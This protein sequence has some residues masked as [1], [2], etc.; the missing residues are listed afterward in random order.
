MH[1]ARP[2]LRDLFE[3][4]VEALPLERARLL[5]EVQ[6]QSPILY[7]HL[8]D[9]LR[10]HEGP[11]AIFDLDGGVWAQL[12]PPSLI[13]RRF[14]AYVIESE[15][16]QGGMGTVYRATRADE[17][18]HKTVAIKIVSGAAVLNESALESF[19]RE[20][21]ILAHLEHPG[22]ARLLD[23]GATEDGL[24]FLVMEFV[25][26]LPF[27]RYLKEKS[28]G[29][30]EILRIVLQVASAVS[31]AH[32][33]LVVHRDLKPSNILVDNAGQVKLLDFGIAKVLKPDASDTRTM[34]VRLTP[35]FASPEQIRGESIS[36]SSDVY[37]LG[38]VLYHAL[39][40]GEQPYQPTSRAVPDLLEA[41]LR[42][43]PRRPSTIAKTPW[44]RKL[45][46]ELDTLVLKAM[47]KEPERRYSSVEQLSDDIGRYLEGR[48]I[49][50]QADN[51]IY[52]SGKFLR[53]NRL[54]VAAAVML[55]VSI[56]SG[57]FSTFQQAAIA[58][59]ER[60]QAIRE[61]QRALEARESAERERANSER[62][63][64]RAEQQAQ[65]ADARNREAQQQR[66]LAVSA[67]AEAEA[68]YQNARSLATAILVDVNAA[69]KSLPGSGPARQRA[70]FAA[71]K[72]LED[73]SR[74]EA[75]DFNLLEDLATAYEQTAEIFQ[76]LN[77]EPRDNANLAI[78]ALEKAIRL[79][80]TVFEGRPQD[81]MSA[82]RLADAWRGLG[83]QQL[84]AGLPSPALS[85]YETS[86][87]LANRFSPHPAAQQRMAL[88]QVN[89][90]VVN[91]ERKS[92][93]EALVQCQA[94]VQL[95]S[96]LPRDNGAEIPRLRALTM[97]RLGNA[98]RAARQPAAAEAQY[99]QALRQIDPLEESMTGILRE[100]SDTLQSASVSRAL[101]IN[102]TWRLGVALERNKNRDGALEHFERCFE[103]STAGGKPPLREVIAFGNAATLHAEAMH[104]ARGGQMQ[105]ALDGARKALALLASNTSEPADLL[106]GEL[107]ASMEAWQSSVGQSPVP[108]LPVPQS[109]RN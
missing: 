45:R 25:D 39:T 63:R 56:A 95:T 41:V 98:M 65:L 36:T 96:N 16:G 70:V 77:G 80:N 31:F 102:A 67:Q 81:M 76:G 12:T 87:N 94:A 90:C 7:G 71:L 27:D 68:R 106:R 14:G 21:Q 8:R 47:A 13:G 57:V 24:L 100:L 78:P 44:A 105:Q 2:S 37:S 49:L 60:E 35:E 72:N 20:R 69:L 97:L 107:H 26:G 51:W 61:R 40:G 66:A 43:D 48:P 58:T 50:A 54:A 75:K 4:A 42:N 52:R 28:P 46:G 91:L 22:I 29:L 15:I 18:F 34:A 62:E 38:V 89:Q 10:A 92:I 6:F 9:M 93:Q 101:R 30:E 55:T 104:A 17:A 3:K 109:P 108:P 79:R 23:G 86:F 59:R 19:R 84:G 11:E 103:I 33:N 83:N 73:L 53:R 99:L 32:R 85:S 64:Q 1:P 74:R 5:R 88:A 82:L